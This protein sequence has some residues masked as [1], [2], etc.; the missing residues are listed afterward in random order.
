[1][2]KKARLLVKEAHLL[3]NIGSYVIVTIK[4]KELLMAGFDIHRGIVVI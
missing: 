4:I 3:V 2:I 1:M